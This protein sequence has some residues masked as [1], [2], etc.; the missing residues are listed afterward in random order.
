MTQ[1]KDRINLNEKLA[2]FD[3]L[4]TPKLV[5]KVNETD[6]RL[7]KIQGTEPVPADL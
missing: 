6:I 4:W 5:A 7:S 2:L 3:E 1:A